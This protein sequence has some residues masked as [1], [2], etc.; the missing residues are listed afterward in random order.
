[1]ANQP[2]NLVLEH[3]RNLRQEMNARFDKITGNIEVLTAEMRISNSHVAGLVQS[4][5]LTSHRLAEL[6]VRLD[7]VERRLEISDSD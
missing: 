2:E 6:E 3:L 4:D 7:R 1:M 5:V